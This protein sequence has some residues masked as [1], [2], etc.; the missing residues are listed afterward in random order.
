M[1][2]LLSTIS[3][4][5]RIEPNIN[6][7]KR[8]IEFKGSTDERIFSIDNADSDFFADFCFTADTMTEVD[9]GKEA[10]PMSIVPSNGHLVSRSRTKVAAIIYANCDIRVNQL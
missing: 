9:W 4:V 1:P 10:S 8:E 7:G 2:N 6:R 3:D 5:G